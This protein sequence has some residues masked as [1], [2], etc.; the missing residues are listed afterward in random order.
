MTEWVFLKARTAAEGAVWRSEDGQYYK[1]TGDVLGE[2]EFQAH[3]FDLEYPVPQIVESGG[4]GD[5]GYFVE[6]S[7]GE[8]SLHDQCKA[9]AESLGVV[10]QTTVADI[11]RVS[12]LLLAAQA[13]NPREPAEWF[14]AAAFAENVY[15]ENTDFDTS[16]VR[17]IVRH[18]LKRLS[19]LPTTW[20]HLDFG[21]PNM[22]RA[23]VIDWQFH[24]LVP[25]GYDVCPALEIVAFKGG[26]KGY[27]FALD[28]RAHYLA[29]LDD[30]A[31]AVT[32]Q[33]LSGFLG[34]FLLVKCFFFLALMRPADSTRRD[35]WIKWQYRRHL[36][37]TGLNSY[38]ASG[39]IDTGAFPTFS[40]F[41]KRYP[42]R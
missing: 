36:F 10:S 6:R 12:C 14:N 20:G 29:A 22:F 21:L 34:E 13:A 19:Q 33:R 35:K 4:K 32:G 9:D 31:A 30:V 1:R 23:G 40:S 38:E 18:A 7:L 15:S 11:T 42:D 17:T 25:L 41:A 26:D 28:Q 2:A 3:M 37:E 27:A 5:D 8:R 24:G 16:H 39:T